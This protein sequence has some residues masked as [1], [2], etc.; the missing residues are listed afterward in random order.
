MIKIFVSPSCSSCR[1]MEKWLETKS[2]PFT[3]KNIIAQPL[4]EQEL[5][6][7]LEKSDLGFED[8]ISTRS[9]VFSELGKS[10]E[11][12]HTNDLIKFIIE[13]PT[14]MKR[15]I[16]VD[17]R[18]MQIG[19]NPEDITAFLPKELKEMAQSYCTDECENFG[20]CDIREKRA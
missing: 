3:K 8:I 18:K 19:Y 20:D 10:L 12:M 14:V 4:N 6:D 11:D 1:K 13:N 16:I 5:R 9:K 17:E 15:P 2:I 7:L